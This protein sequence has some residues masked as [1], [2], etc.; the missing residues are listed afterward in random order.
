[1]VLDD[2]GLHVRGERALDG[3]ALEGDRVIG[4][5]DVLGAQLARDRDPHDETDDDQRDSAEDAE[6]SG[7]LDESDLLLRRFEGVGG[8]GV[9]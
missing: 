2:V 1:M 4:D 6:D 9:L 7:D 3:L 8:G 5:G